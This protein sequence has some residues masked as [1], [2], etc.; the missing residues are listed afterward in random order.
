M[1]FLPRPH[2]L[3]LALG[4]LLGLAAWAVGP[5]ASDAGPDPRCFVFLTDDPGQPLCTL[6]W[7]VSLDDGTCVTFIQ[8]VPVIVPEHQQHNATARWQITQ[9]LLAAA[10]GDS[11]RIAWTVEQA[12]RLA[13][14]Y[15]TL[16]FDQ[17]LIDAVDPEP[18]DPKVDM[19]GQ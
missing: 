5:G 13:K 3:A 17:I 11:K 8:R 16:G 2:P 1:I 15:A 9:D 7:I 4:C 14:E 10:E 19:A 18:P 12:G 6:T